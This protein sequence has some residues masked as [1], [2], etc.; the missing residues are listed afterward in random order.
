[1]YK[2]AFVSWIIYTF[3]TLAFFIM[4]AA[5]LHPQGLSPKGNEMI[6]TLSRMYTDTL[7]EWAS[8]LFLVGA[9]AVLGST[10][11][12]AIPSWARMYTNLLAEVGLIDWHD[13]ETRLRWSSAASPSSC[14]ASIRR[15]ACSRSSA[16]PRGSRRRRGRSVGGVSAA[17]VRT[18]SRS[19]LGG[20]RGQSGDV[21]VHQEGIEDHRRSRGEQRPG[22]QP[23]PVIDVAADQR[24]DRAHGQDQLVLAVQERERIEELRPGDRDDN[25]VLE[26]GRERRVQQQIRVLLQRWLGVDHPGIARHARDLLVR[27]ERGD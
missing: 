20:P 1:M 19:A 15:S 21:V 2:D 25:G 22:H 14:W 27:F 7:G 11:W 18:A 8:I 3:G 10:L 9:I 6:T 12:A 13:T 4:G 24:G 16:E 23:A 17:A 26:I 5:V